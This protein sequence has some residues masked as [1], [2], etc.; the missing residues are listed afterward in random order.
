MKR[1][2]IITREIPADLAKIPLKRCEGLAEHSLR[3]SKA[4]GQDFIDS[5]ILACY[6]AGMDDALQLKEQRR[7]GLYEEER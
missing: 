5:L 1:D 7:E 3:I 2:R 6:T 4:W